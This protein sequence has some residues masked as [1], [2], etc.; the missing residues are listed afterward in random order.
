MA[1]KNIQALLGTEK[2]KEEPR[3]QPETVQWVD[4]GWYVVLEFELTGSARVEMAVELARSHPHFTE[5]VD[6]R[7]RTLYRNIY[8][9]RDFPKFDALYSIVGSWKSTRTYLKGDEIERNRF[10]PWYLSYRTYW[11]HRKML[12]EAD[13]CG[14]SRTSPFPDFLGCYDRSIILKH[15]DPMFSSYQYSS[16]VWYHFGKRIRD[17]F[18]LDKSGMLAY[19]NRVNEDYLSCPCYGHALIDHFITKL[20]REINPAVH[21][22]WVF[23][24]DYLKAQV[25]VLFNYEIAMSTMPEVCPVSEKAYVDF[26]TR[27]FKSE[28]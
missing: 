23:K 21:K 28:D 9:K 11:G 6:E 24:E 4:R 17:A 3:P 8:F 19:L 15:R 10:E 1:K 18:V 5:L 27:L 2:Q 12:N 20:P 14:T 26:M 13:A 22:E 16:K 25:R 7:G